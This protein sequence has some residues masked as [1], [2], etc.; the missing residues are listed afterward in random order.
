M[1]CRTDEWGPTRVGRTV[2]MY[3]GVAELDVVGT[4]GEVL[5]DLR[6]VLLFLALILVLLIVGGFGLAF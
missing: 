6:F 5:R 4:W 3:L 2:C 1:V